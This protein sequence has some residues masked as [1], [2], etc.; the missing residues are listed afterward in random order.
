MA[1]GT[2]LGCS[3]HLPSM[4]E[5]ESGWEEIQI[6]SRLTCVHIGEHQVHAVRV[7]LPSQGHLV[8]PQKQEAR[9]QEHEVPCNTAMGSPLGLAGGAACL[10]D[11]PQKWSAQC[12]YRPL[13]NTSALVGPGWAPEEDGFMHQVAKPT[14]LHTNQTSACP[15]GTLHTVSDYVL[16]KFA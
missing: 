16:H 10:V 5:P 15:L 1:C 11:V 7:D 8:L 2:G 6:T 3:Q 14:G 4:A 13:G 12:Q 9:R